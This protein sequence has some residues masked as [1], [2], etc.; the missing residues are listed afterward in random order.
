MLSGAPN[1]FLQSMFERFAEAV[2]PTACP[3]LKLS[4]KP[5]AHPY[6]YCLIWELDKGSVTHCLQG[7]GSPGSD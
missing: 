4:E 2:K 5:V 7:I 1:R 6:L 3:V